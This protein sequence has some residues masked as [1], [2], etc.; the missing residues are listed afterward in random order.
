MIKRGLLGILVA[1][2]IINSVF[3][4]ELCSLETKLINQDP[5]PAIP[6]DYV[7]LVFQIN[8]VENP[9]CGKVDISLKEV[10]PFSLDPKENSTKTINSGI[11]ERTYNSFFIVP[12][13]VRINENAFD[14][15][16]QIELVT[17]SSKM[18]I[19][20]NFSI[21][22]KDSR[23]DFEIFVKDYKPLTKIITFEILNTGK[24]NVKALTLE[25]PR[26]EHLEVKGS[27][28]NIVGDLDSN[29]YSTADFEASGGGNIE[30]N[31]Y[32][33]DS[34]QVRRNLSKSIIFEP[35]YFENRATDKKSMSGTYTIIAIIIL[36]LAFFIYRRYSKK[37]AR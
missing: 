21:N 30:L 15:E 6:G 14:G 19:L 1:L 34:I 8:G 23:S 35:T 10:F 20:N 17:S 16:T 37:R 33:T 7:K 27:N 18:N 32:Y 31:L 13:K 22:I 25:I 24:N 2:L 5:Y 12:Y 29:E 11:Y 3:A 9:N 26:Q 28:R 36:F 4:S